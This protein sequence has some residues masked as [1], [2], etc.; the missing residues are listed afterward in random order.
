VVAVMA[1]YDALPHKQ[2]KGNFDWSEPHLFAPIAWAG[3]WKDNL[4]PRKCM[5]DDCTI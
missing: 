4:D 3:C 2:L 5:F 1:A